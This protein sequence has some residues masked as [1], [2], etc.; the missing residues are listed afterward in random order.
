MRK[1]Q[2]YAGSDAAPQVSVVVPNHQGA[3]YLSACLNSLA[4]QTF[5]DF[6]VIISDDGS[7]DGSRE[8][9]R[10]LA[11][12]MPFSLKFF[13]LGENRG[14]PFAVNRGVEAARG[15]LVALLNND[16]ECDKD[17]LA[18]LVAAA[19]KFPDAGFF[20]SK[21]LLSSSRGFYDCAGN[22]VTTA[23]IGE[24]RKRFLPL[25]AGEEGRAVFGA[26]AAAS[27]Y[28]REA[29]DAAGPL[30]ESYF[31]YYED[32]DFDMR[33]NLAGFSCRYAPEAVVYHHL[34]AAAR[35]SSLS[36][37]I[38]LVSRN[39]EAFFFTYFPRP[40]GLRHLANHAALVFIQII[41]YLLR[42]N[43][44]AYLA[45]KLAFLR[46]FRKARRKRRAIFARIGAGRGVSARFA[47]PWLSRYVS[48]VLAQRR[49][50]KL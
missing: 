35:G 22:C 1:L 8:I 7:D 30:D 2:S 36:R 3:R 15:K 42:G 5:R 10:G 44:S 45:G 17:W 24:A 23:G 39:M 47:R 20:A 25:E 32:L 11:P 29:L 4:T 18:A 19:E 9:V 28:R 21:I 27:M 50:S 48:S 31:M 14:F 6:E 34:G 37:R 38:F 43:I 49:F 33:L 16:T 41:E 46:M 12:K 13:E 26:C 40:F